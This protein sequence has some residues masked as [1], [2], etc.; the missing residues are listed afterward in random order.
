MPLQIKATKWHGQPNWQ[1]P[2]CSHASIGR[3]ENMEAHIAAKHPTQLRLAELEGAESEKAPTETKPE[4][5]PGLFGFGTPA[6]AKEG[7][8]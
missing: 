2:F 5:A 7:G 1:C 3:R 4:K 6:D 8:E